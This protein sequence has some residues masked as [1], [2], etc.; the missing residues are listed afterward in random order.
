MAKG[1]KREGAGRPKN[2]KDKKPRVRRQKKLPVAKK[3][4]NPLVPSKA[5]Y[6]RMEKYLSAGNK[7]LYHSLINEFESP[8]ECL[9]AMRN[10][11]VARYNLGRIGEMEEA[12]HIRKLAKDGLKEIKTDNTLD[13]RVL[14]N[15]Q[16]ADAIRRLKRQE[17]AYPELSSKVTAL[18]SEIRQV[19]ELIDRIESGNP[20]N[21]INLFNLLDGKVSKKKTIE[22]RNR[23]FDIGEVDEELE[24]DDNEKS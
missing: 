5:Q 4:P 21:V 12:S 15:I 13:G 9:K 10:D 1:G 6:L 23:V 2:I 18:A 16:K 7:K 20:A 11:L 24:E 14:T 8:T 19:N 3:E 17:K 22:I